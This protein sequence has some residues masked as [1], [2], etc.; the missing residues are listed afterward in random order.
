MPDTDV[1]LEALSAQTAALERLAV[2]LGPVV[3]PALR[4]T[5]E[6]QRWAPDAAAFGDTPSPLVATDANGNPGKPVANELIESAWGVAVANRVVLTFPNLAAMNAA[7]GTVVGNVGVTVDNGIM[8][9]RL[10]AGWARVTPLSGFVAGSGGDYPA[11][12]D[13][14]GYQV[15][16]D[17][18]PR[19]ISFVFNAYVTNRT[20]GT[21]FLE[22]IMAGAQITVYQ[23]PSTTVNGASQINLALMGWPIAAGATPLLT[24]RNTVA[25]AGMSA[26][27]SLNSLSVQVNPA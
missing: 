1:L 7:V 16:A 14:I 17:P 9:R 10:A 24:I 19:T 4:P 23:H 21:M 12:T 8:Y 3:T 13:L 15:S 6:Q 22:A 5:W 26:S 2:A 20:G 27:A 11:G 25:S 18:G